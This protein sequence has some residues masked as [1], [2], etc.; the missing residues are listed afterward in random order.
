MPPAATSAAGSD[1]GIPDRATVKM[2]KA[3]LQNAPEFHYRGRDAARVGNT[4]P[5]VSSTAPATRP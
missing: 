4:N 2:T 1:D 3:D 5:P